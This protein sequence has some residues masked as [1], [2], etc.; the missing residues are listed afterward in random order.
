MALLFLRIFVFLSTLFY[1]VY[2][3]ANLSLFSY[4]PKAKKA[5]QKARLDF[6]QSLE[7]SDE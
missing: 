7:Y 4:T 5:E 2:E 3:F 6:L 1:T